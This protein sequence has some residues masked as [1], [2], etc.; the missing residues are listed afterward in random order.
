[1]QISPALWRSLIKPAWKRVLDAVRARHPIDDLLPAQLRQ[2][3]RHRAGHRGARLPR[4]ASHPAG[5]HGPRRGE[6]PRMGA[7]SCRARHSGRSARSLSG[8]RGGGAAGRPRV[9]MD[10]IGADRRCIVCPSNR[11]QPETPWENV[12]AFAAAARSHRFGRP[13]SRAPTP[14]KRRASPSRMSSGRCTAH[15][16]RRYRRACRR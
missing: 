4:P 6:G 16:A 11:V 3:H 9:L 2:H 8:S 1:M 10:T 14:S 5:V 13:G 7:G 12:L 15:R